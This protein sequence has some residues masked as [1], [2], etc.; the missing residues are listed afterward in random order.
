MWSRVIEAMLGVWL[1]MSPFIF[2]YSSEPRSLWINDF[3]AGG[4]CMIFG[5]LSYWQ[6]ARHAHVANLIVACWLIGFACLRSGWPVSP[7]YQNYV[8]IGLLLF[9]FAV[10][11][12][13]ADE[14]P[15][16][17]RENFEESH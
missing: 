3:V 13:R 15:S 14:P 6:P 8:I 5:I 9:M 17:R 7:P 12:N 4:L 16:F 11:P 10:I 2:R 1:W